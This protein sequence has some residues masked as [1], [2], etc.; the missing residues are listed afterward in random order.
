[1]GQF[2]K[3]LNNVLCERFPQ[4]S[5]IGQ[6]IIKYYRSKFNLCMNFVNSKSCYKHSFVNDAK[7][8]VKA[9]SWWGAAR[10]AITLTLK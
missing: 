1:M 5:Q 4:H 7:V 3:Y 6:V 8:C 9:A 2:H 10:A